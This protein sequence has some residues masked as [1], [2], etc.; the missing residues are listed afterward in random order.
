[1]AVYKWVEELFA[2]CFD[3][4]PDDADDV[5]S[6]TK[7]MPRYSNEVELAVSPIGNLRG[8]AGYHSSVLLGSEEFYFSPFGICCSR[9][10]SSHESSG[11]KRIFVGHSNVTSKEIIEILSD[12]FCPGSYD[13]IRKNCNAFTDCALYLLCARRL[14]SS[15]RALDVLGQ[16]ADSAKLVQALSLGAYTPNEKADGFDLEAVIQRIDCFITARR[17]QAP[18]F[19]PFAEYQN[20]PWMQGV[21][22]ALRGHTTSPEKSCARWTAALDNKVASPTKSRRRSKSPRK[23]RGSDPTSSDRP[24]TL[25]LRS[26]SADSLQESTL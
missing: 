1:M 3:C 11:V 22:A 12:D 7:R 23:S 10:L 16:V 14:D 17:H 8:A 18:E 24:S 25:T 13:L 6:P 2:P 19:D 9:K 26:S 15:F 21:E 5:K 4:H 20:E